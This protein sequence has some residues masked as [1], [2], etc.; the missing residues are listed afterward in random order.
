MNKKTCRAKKQ[1]SRDWL[2]GG[3]EMGK[4]I[5]EMDW[6]KTPLGPIEKW[7]QSLRTTV[8]LCLASNFPISIAWGP[9]RT[10]IY[11]DGYR[12]IC[13]AKHPHSMGQGFKECWLSAWP[14]I[15]E[16]FDSAGSGKTAFLINRRMFLDRYGYV[17]ETFFTFSFSPIRDES[18]DVVGLFHPVIEMTQQTLAERR[19]QILRDVAGRT[20]EAKAVD[21]A[22]ES[23]AQALP[24]ANS[25]CRL[26][27]STC[28]MLM[29]D[30]PRS[31]GA[32]DSR[33]VLPPVPRR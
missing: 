2:T 1:P 14:A 15:G 8:S 12:P 6:S 23:I 18:G 11:N 32:R 28:S 5:C 26:R 27:C 7:P 10:Q 9:Q 33:P 3:G 31:P 17:E 29:E 19:L 30:G 16:A 24:C 4:L 21:E 25:T 22:C 13:G 20:A